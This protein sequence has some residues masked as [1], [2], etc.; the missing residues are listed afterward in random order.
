ML[1]IYHL[2]WSFSYYNSELSAYRCSRRLQ[3]LGKDIRN[4]INIS[5]LL[6]ERYLLRVWIKIFIFPFIQRSSIPCI[7]FALSLI[8]FKNFKCSLPIIS[9]SSILSFLRLLNYSEAF[10]MLDRA[11][12]IFSVTSES[13]FEIL[14]FLLAIKFFVF[15][16]DIWTK[17]LLEFPRLMLL[18]L[19][20]AYYTFSDLSWDIEWLLNT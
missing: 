5:T 17:G 11:S 13:C 1:T 8:I 10:L 4:H 7:D 14:S 20:I 18:F 15:S 2:F 9:F 19:S 3:D 16:L 12:L 6:I